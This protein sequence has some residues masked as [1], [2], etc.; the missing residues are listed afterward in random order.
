MHMHMLHAQNPDHRLQHTHALSLNVAH[1]RKWNQGPYGS[2][3][4]MLKAQ[5]VKE[6]WSASGAQPEYLCKLRGSCRHNELVLDAS[7]WE[8]LLPDTVEAVFFTALSS[9]EEAAFARDVHAEFLRHFSLPAASV[10][11]LRLNLTRASG[12]F[13]L[14]AGNWT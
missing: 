12:P 11:L 7:S 2:V 8:A 3:E 1:R 6:R 9:V 4:L 14:V 13:E 10:P 5:L